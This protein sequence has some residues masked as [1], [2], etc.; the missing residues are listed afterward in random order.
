VNPS[1][2]TEPPMKA[3]LFLCTALSGSALATPPMTDRI[4]PAQM[5][6]LQQTE[7]PMVAL[8]K[9]Q[10]ASE[11]EAKV[12]RPGD[13]SLI[14]QSE[15]LNDGTHWTLVPKGAVLHVPAARAASVGA[16]PLGTL[17][18]WNDFLVANR[19]WLSA[20]EITYDQAAGNQKLPVNRTDYWKKQDKVIVAVHQGGPISVKVV[21]PVTTAAAQP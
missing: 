12:V 19:A 10:K 2:T 4:T 9:Q 14:K 21:V 13:Q 1:R 7:S 15:I 11:A 18:S 17:L 6:E 3:Y 20:E 8:Q 16:K 5:A